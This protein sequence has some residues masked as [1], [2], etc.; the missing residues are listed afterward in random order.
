MR[1][2]ERILVV[3]DENLARALLCEL[4]GQYMPDAKIDD[5]GNP[6]VALEMMEETLYS[7]LFLDYEMPRMN[8]GE[9]LEKITG[10]KYPPAVIIVSAH[11][12]F[13]F[14][15]KGIR[16]GVI[17]YV[18][19]PIDNRQIKDVIDKYRQKCGSEP[20]PQSE[21]I[22]ID[23]F[24][25]K[26]PVKKSSIAA[27][28]MLTRS[29]LEIILTNGEKLPPTTSSL[30]AVMSLLPENFIYLNRRCIINSD[31]IRLISNSYHV[32]FRLGDQVITEKC[33]RKK[34]A[35]LRQRF[36]RR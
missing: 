28:K 34:M 17:D 4:V 14:A 7:L 18:V 33:S 21:V 15:Q 5:A 22:G 26:I 19:K 35:E 13:D 27:I 2:T 9:L 12:D 31:M 10:R 30:H 20:S 36:D 3:D 16:C 8:G 11:K 29:S 23:T 24:K 6:L 1:K 32:E 25:G